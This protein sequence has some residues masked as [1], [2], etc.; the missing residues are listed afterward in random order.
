[1]TFITAAV[2]AA[3]TLVGI[4]ILART[5]LS[6]WNGWLDLQRTQLARP[7]DGTHHALGMIDL[8]DIKER[9]RKLEAIAAGVDL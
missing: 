7:A 1:M 4:A 6:A 5:A 8:S 9:L 3:A 2:L